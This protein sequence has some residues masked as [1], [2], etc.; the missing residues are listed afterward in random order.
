MRPAV[1]TSPDGNRFMAM[2][3]AGMYAYDINRSP[4]Q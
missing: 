1:V 3:T 2:Q 4:T